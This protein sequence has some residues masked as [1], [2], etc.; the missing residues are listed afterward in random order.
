MTDYPLPESF[1][2]DRLENLAAVRAAGI[3]PYPYAFHGAVPLAEVVRH[4]AQLEGQSV[5]TAGRITSRREMG[6]TTFL[7]LSDGEFRFQIYVRRDR[8]NPELFRLVSKRLD[9][10]DMIGV[11]GELF[12]TQKGEHSL[13]VYSLEILAKSVVVIPYGKR[14]DERAF[15]VPAHIEAKRQDRVL[16]W[17]TDP[18][19]RKRFEQRYRILGWIREFMN[20]EGFLE[21]E[22]PTIEPLY[23]G[24]EARP[25]T[26]TIWALD[27][28]RAYLRISPELYLKRFIVGGFPRVYTICSN[29]RNENIDSTHNPEFTMMEWYEAL[30]DYED[31]MSRFENICCHVAQRLRGSLRLEYRGREIDLTPPWPRL[32]VPQLVE[33]CFGK[34]FADLSLRE[35]LERMRDRGM[36]PEKVKRAA[37][38]PKGAVVMDLL[39]H[40][41]GD[42]LWGPCFLCDH[43]RDIS[44]LTKARRGQPGFV[45]RFE[46]FV[47]GMELGNAYS[48]LTDPLEQFQRFVEQRRTRGQQDYEDH[49]IDYDFLKAV[50]YG[51]P[52]TGGAGLGIDRLIMLLLGVESIRDIIPFPMR[53]GETS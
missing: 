44:P 2:P 21:V 34:P 53:K 48:E 31:Q 38:E 22:T 24:A 20:G 17:L 8:L 3:D 5:R 6:K 30:T 23:G 50:G 46:P 52:P 45:E 9:L 1:D 13:N 37:D 14:T 36:D 19:S 33:K 28:Q 51:M 32:R 40:E 18:S 25:F 41:L 43:P 16:D 7:D 11:E 4:F 10:G 27:D 35:C 39:E 42:T 29:F 49:P 12:T 26:T 47:A 15:Y